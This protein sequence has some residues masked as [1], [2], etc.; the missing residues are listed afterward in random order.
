[1]IKGLLINDV[2]FN[3]CKIFEKLITKRDI[4]TQ[5]ISFELNKFHS[6]IIFYDI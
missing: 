4:V 3:L 5:S 1:M 2:N 6:S